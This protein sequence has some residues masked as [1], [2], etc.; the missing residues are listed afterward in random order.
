[1]QTK[2]KITIRSAFIQLKLA[3]QFYQAI[4]ML[5]INL[6][7]T[8]MVG[9]KGSLGFNLVLTIQVWVWVLYDRCWN[10][11]HYQFFSDPDLSTDRT[12]SL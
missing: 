4:S 2:H 10:R 12:L 3:C 7:L 1:M 9:N 11:A 6:G 8:T 5:P